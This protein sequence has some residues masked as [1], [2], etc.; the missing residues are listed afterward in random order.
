[1]KLLVGLG[2]QLLTSVLKLSFQMFGESTLSGCTNLNL[3]GDGRSNGNDIS[4]TDWYIFFLTEY[5]NGKRKGK[6]PEIF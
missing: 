2:E 1:M 5:K 3:V 6:N 4:Y